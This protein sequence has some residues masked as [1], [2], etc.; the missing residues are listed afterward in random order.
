MSGSARKEKPERSL[1][2]ASVIRRYVCIAQ[3]VSIII[4]YAALSSR[5]GRYQILLSYWQE[6]HRQAFTFGYQN[7]DF[8]Q[9]GQG[10]FCVAG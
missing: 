9:A 1:S 2:P 8:L 6:G 4:R 7:I 5:T 10:F 3:N